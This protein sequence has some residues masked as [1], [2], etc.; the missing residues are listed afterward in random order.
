MKRQSDPAEICFGLDRQTDEQSLAHFIRR[1]A[2]PALLEA[3]IPRLSDAEITETL[4]FLSKMMGKH[5][6]E[7]EYHTLFLAGKG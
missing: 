5:L 1:F 2:S 7:K 6:K 3:L 4:D